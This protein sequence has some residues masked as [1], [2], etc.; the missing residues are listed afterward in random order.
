MAKSSDKSDKKNTVLLVC[1]ICIIVMLFSGSVLYIVLKNKSLSSLQAGEDSVVTAY[2]YSDGCLIRTIDLSSAGDEVFDVS[3]GNGGFNTVTIKDHDICVSS[4]SCP[5][6][7]CMKEGYALKSPVPIVC[8][9]NKLVII[10]EKNENG[11]EVHYDAV[12]Y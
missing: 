3:S 7:L 12:T 4:A 6:G 2:I 10:I 5:D 11:K 9:P 8:L 1:L